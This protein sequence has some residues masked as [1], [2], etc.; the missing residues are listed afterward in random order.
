M[1]TKIKPKKTKEKTKQ[2]E[3]EEFSEAEVLNEI[4]TRIRKGK[5]VSDWEKEL[6]LEGYSVYDAP[7]PKDIQKKLKQNKKNKKPNDKQK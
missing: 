3:D 4:E 1:T 5:P 2:K 7:I 6:L